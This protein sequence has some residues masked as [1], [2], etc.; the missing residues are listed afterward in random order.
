MTHVLKQSL[1]RVFMKSRDAAV[2]AGRNRIG[3]ARAPPH[4]SQQGAE[5]FTGPMVSFRGIANLDRVLLS[6]GILM[7]PRLGIAK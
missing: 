6:G 2:A 4:S 3:T 5:A 1:K 7:R